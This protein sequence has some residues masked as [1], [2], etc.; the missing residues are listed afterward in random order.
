M[1]VW[2]IN[3]AYR[4]TRRL[5]GIIAVLIRYGFGEVLHRMQLARPAF[6]LRRFFGAAKGVPAPDSSVGE[7][8][9]MAF[10]ELGPTFIKLGQLLTTRPDVVPTDVIDHLKKLQR[11]VPPESFE[12][13]RKVIKEELG[14][15]PEELFEEIETE[16]LGSA[17]VAQ[18]HRARLPGGEKVAVKV[19]KPSAAE[20]IP[21]D[22]D[23][24]E[25]LV[26]MLE[27]NV[28]ESRFF[29][30]RKIF[31]QF[32]RSIQRELD[33]TFEAYTM[34]SFAEAHQEDDEVVI[35]RVHWDWTGN[36]I[37]TMTL[38]EGTPLTEM[39]SLK[40]AGTDLATFADLG[41]GVVLKQ[42]FHYGLFHGDPHPGN[43]Y[44][45]PDGRLGLLDYGIAGRLSKGSREQLT[46]IL[47]AMNRRDAGDLALVLMDLNMGESDVDF[48]SLRERLADFIQSYYGVP[49]KHLKVGR[50]IAEGFGILREHG[51]EIPPHLAL[52]L[53]V[54]AQVESVGRSLD[55]EFSVMEAVTPF[56]RDLMRKRLEPGEIARENVDLA[57][58]VWSVLARTPEDL[59]QIMRKIRSGRIKVELGHQGLTDLLKEQ[60]RM[61]NRISFA[62]ITGSVVVG[63][64]LLFSTRIGPSFMGM[65]VF[66]L[67]GFL[68][69]AGLGMW[70]AVD[71][72]RSGKF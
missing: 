23:I 54:L 35:P 67:L 41:S 58:E 26:G 68:I 63:S 65:P 37:L 36:R 51:V 14:G 22:L 72:L 52:L 17:S 3:R 56:A 28:E 46:E 27:R 53:K 34:N 47:L 45:L 11:Q 38:I 9:R 12:D 7:R 30:P 24:I 4:S 49:L 48:I 57:R 31:E 8:L 60:D 50:V 19:V 43:L 2:N 61:S 55:P 66:G 40:S 42:I 29:H 18:V 32:K 64:S 13:I 33:L 70:L 69:A 44:Y 16:P 25:G 39:D 1:K 71:I 10:E 21:A 20:Q 62:I 15:S 6:R 5:A 59:G